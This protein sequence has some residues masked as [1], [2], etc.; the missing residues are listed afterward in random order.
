MMSMLCRLQRQRRVLALAASLLAVTTAHAADFHGQIDGAAKAANDQVIGWRRAIHQHPELAFQEKRTAALV[1]RELKALGY[2]VRTGVA[3]TGVVAVLKGGKPGGSV[4]LRADMDALP[5]KEPSGLAFASTDTGTWDGKTVPVMHACGHDAHTAIL[6]GVATVLAKMRAELPGTVTLLFQPG[7]ETGWDKSRDGAARML[8]EGAFDMAHPTAVFGLHVAS[9]Y[10]VGQ[11]AYRGG[12]IQASYDTVNIEVHGKQTHGSAPWT[13]T[14]AVV[15]AATVVTSLQTVVSR[16]LNTLSTPTVFTIGSIHGGE[17]AGIIPE[18]VRMEGAISTFS[19]Q[20]RQ[21]A[22]DTIRRTAEAAAATVGAQAR[23]ELAEGYPV[24]VNNPELSAWAKAP[25][26]AVFGEQG[27]ITMP[28]P[29]TGSED[30]SY[31]AQ[32][33][34]GVFFYLGVTTQGTD[35]SQAPRGHSPNFNLDESAL[36]Y[37]VRALSYLATD[38]LP[39]QPK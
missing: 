27:V 19:E 15:G 21:Q 24:N 23:V 4:A 7:E 36:Q 37:G 34:P 28:V 2:Q 20:M 5:V 22:F 3:D 1:A 30:F 13:G 39:S 29:S 26:D 16:Q 35:A 10:N 8:A 6:L 12:P 31:Y 32:A 38:Y 14:D 33:V 17:R 25:L 18:N 9:T 11:M